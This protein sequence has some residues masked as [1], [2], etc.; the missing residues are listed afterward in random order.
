MAD[1]PHS[2]ETKHIP[3]SR[4]VCTPGLRALKD[5]EVRKIA[6]SMASVGLITPITVNL[7]YKADNPDEE[8]SPGQTKYYI[9]AGRHRFMAAQQ[10]GWSTIECFV[11]FDADEIDAELWEIAENLHRCVLSRDERDEHLR[12][13]ATLLRSKETA[14][15]NCGTS[16]PDGRKA[17]HQHLPGIAS[18]V[19]KETGVSKD[20]VERALNPERVAAERAR[21]KIDAD[22]KARAAKEVASM[23]S[24]HVPGEWWDALKAN[25]YAAGAANIANELTNIIGQS[26]M[27]QRYGT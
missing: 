26:L 27:D 24:E 22:V 6:D 5:E 18:I 19:A 7:G 14:A 2:R 12:R 21:S 23:L 16:L 9:I 17:G 4:I 10:L 25:L 3:L 8:V 15:A 20:T 1:K 11:D 13:Y